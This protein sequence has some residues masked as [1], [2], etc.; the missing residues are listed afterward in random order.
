M[1]GLSGIN[2]QGEE[3]IKTGITCEMFLMNKAKIREH[4][5]KAEKNV[6]KGEKLIEKQEERLEEMARD[7]HPT[8]I[9]EENLKVLREVQETMK[10]TRDAV[11]EELA[12]NIERKAR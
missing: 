1:P 2:D 9:H 3:A 10:K 7:G 4:L 8:K 5:D 6:E 12:E 11:R